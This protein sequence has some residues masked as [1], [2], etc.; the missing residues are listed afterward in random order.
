MAE[1]M[2]AGGV[3]SASFSLEFLFDNLLL[4]LGTYKEATPTRQSKRPS[5]YSCSTS[6]L[7]FVVDK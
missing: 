1:F 6:E 5:G 2:Y 4:S 3:L 7:I